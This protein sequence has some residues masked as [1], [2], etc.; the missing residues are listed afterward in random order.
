MAIEIKPD[1]PLSVLLHLHPEL[2][3]VLAARFK[4]RDFNNITE[5]VKTIEELAEEESV[6]IESVL[7]DIRKN[8]DL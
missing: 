1:T 6:D 7:N 2:Q 4:N 5:R 3:E 8:L